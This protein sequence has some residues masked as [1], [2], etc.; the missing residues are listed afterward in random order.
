MLYLLGRVDRLL[1]GSI[2]R[3]GGVQRTGKCLKVA[4]RQGNVLHLFR[5]H[6]QIKTGKGRR[7]HVS[8]LLSEIYTELSRQLPPRVKRL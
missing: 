3:K 7:G 6:R 2:G 4:S 1:Q 8:L 5:Q